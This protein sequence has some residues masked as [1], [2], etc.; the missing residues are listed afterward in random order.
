MFQYIGTVSFQKKFFLTKMKKMRER[1]TGEQG[2][3]QGSFEME[4]EGEDVTFVAY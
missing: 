2:A 1:L 4:E 3:V